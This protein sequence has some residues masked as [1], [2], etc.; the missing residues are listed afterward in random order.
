MRCLTLEAVAQASFSLRLG[1]LERDKKEGREYT[2]FDADEKKGGRG[3]LRRFTGKRVDFL[4]REGFRLVSALG[5]CVR[6]DGWVRPF[7]QHSTHAYPPTQ[8]QKHQPKQHPKQMGHAIRF[9][10]PGAYRVGLNPP[11]RCVRYSP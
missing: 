1:L 4:V 5:L 6:M 10:I 8:Q 3:L 11:F 9:P 7:R 2:Y